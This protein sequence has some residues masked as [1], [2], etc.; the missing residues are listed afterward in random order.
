[1]SKPNRKII[2][3]GET[4]DVWEWKFRGDK[5]PTYTVAVRHVDVRLNGAFDDKDAAIAAAEAADEICDWVNVA[6]GANVGKLA[7]RRMQY[8]VAWLAI[9][10]LH[11]GLPIPGEGSPKFVVSETEMRRRLQA[12]PQ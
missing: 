10:G 1:M 7:E 2:W 5:D 4:L 6:R 8:H 12:V 3:T 11:G 9:R